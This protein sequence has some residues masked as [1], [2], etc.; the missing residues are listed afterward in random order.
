MPTGCGEQ[1]A[2]VG[3]RNAPRGNNGLLGRKH[4]ALLKRWATPELEFLSQMPGG[5]RTRDLPSF[6]VNYY[7]TLILFNASKQNKVV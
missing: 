7:Y 5:E 3:Q 2:Q 1:L 6:V 4:K